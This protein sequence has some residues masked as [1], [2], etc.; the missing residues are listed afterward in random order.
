MFAFTG[1][2]RVFPPL[3]RNETVE[4][5]FIE[6][7]PWILKMIYCIPSGNRDPFIVETETKFSM[8]FGINILKIV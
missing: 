2:V 8:S 1:N 7:N 6:E 5:I 3:I 4:S